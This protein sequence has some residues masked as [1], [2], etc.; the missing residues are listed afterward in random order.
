MSHKAT[1]KFNIHGITPTWNVFTWSSRGVNW[2]E[3]HFWTATNNFGVCPIMSLFCPWRSLFCPWVSL[4]CP[5]LPLSCP[6]LSLCG[7]GCTSFIPLLLFL[8][9]EMIQLL[10]FAVLVWPLGCPHLIKNASGELLFWNS[11]CLVA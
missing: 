11:L 4:F 8:L 2:Y 7:P 3:Q 5:W 6:W 9:N 10:P 1:S